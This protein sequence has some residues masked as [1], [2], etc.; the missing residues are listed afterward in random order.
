VSLHAD[1]ANFSS[2]TV[3]PYIGDEFKKEI[4]SS[5]DAFGKLATLAPRASAKITGV[6]TSSTD[7]KVTV[8]PYVFSDEVLGKVNSLWTVIFYIVLASIYS[9][10][11]M[12]LYFVVG[13]T[14][15]GPP[16]GIG[17][18][19]LTVV[20]YVSIYLVLYHVLIIIPTYPQDSP[21]YPT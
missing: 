8:T 2:L 9:L 12:I 19:I 6:I 5:G 3:E 17:F 4:T 20:I 7:N 13:I 21:A 14:E 1:R 15:F 18:T 11:F 16:W 10:L